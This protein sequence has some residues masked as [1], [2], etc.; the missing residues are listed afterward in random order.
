MNS[1]DNNCF[2]SDSEAMKLHR[3]CVCVQPCNVK[4]SRVTHKTVTLIEIE[5]LLYF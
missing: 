5:I 2:N 3:F 4:I 1:V